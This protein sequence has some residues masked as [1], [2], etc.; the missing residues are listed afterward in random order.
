MVPCT[1]AGVAATT[2][3]ERRLLPARTFQLAQV[4]TPIGCAAAATAAVACSQTRPGGLVW[5]RGL[6]NAVAE[7][8]EEEEAKEQLGEQPENA[9]AAAADKSNGDT[10][11]ATPTDTSHG[12]SVQ[13]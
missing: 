8:V 2:D 6:P 11:D 4:P 10:V 3:G 1:A 7:Q 12:P 13:R 9:R 5:E